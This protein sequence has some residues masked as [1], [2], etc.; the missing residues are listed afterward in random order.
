MN[1]YVLNYSMYWSFSVAKFSG[2][3]FQGSTWGFVGETEF[4]VLSLFEL[5][6]FSQVD[7]YFKGK[8]Y[9]LWLARHFRSWFDT[10][11]SLWCIVIFGR[12]KVRFEVEGKLQWSW[13]SEHVPVRRELLRKVFHLTF[14]ISK[15]IKKWIINFY[16]KAIQSF[17]F[18]VV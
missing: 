3:I 15:L 1:V 18:I 9:I 4:D 13:G 17:Y 5:E 8:N 2:S 11:R 7:D 12:R 14:S 10:W 16:S 6:A